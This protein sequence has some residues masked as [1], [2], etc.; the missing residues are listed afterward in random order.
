MI[1][2]KEDFYFQLP[3]NAVVAEVGVLTGEN[4]K[5]IKNITHPSKLVLVDYWAHLSDREDS[6]HFSVATDW[7]R[8]FGSAR[9]AFKGDDTVF[10]V[11]AM[12]W[13]AASLFAD[14][15]FDWVFVDASHTYEDC[16]KDLK[17]WYPKVKSGGYLCG[18]D[19][20]DNAMT[21]AKGWGVKR[22]VDTF[23]S[24]KGLSIEFTSNEVAARYAIRVR[25]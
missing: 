14:Q 18:H 2:S 8:V 4:A 16:M 24:D 1:Y 17:A 19:Y 5:T 7:N 23:M 9:N 6:I 10:F 25:H 13:Q 20:V 21:Q 12:S 11:A 15:Y 3:S 22:A